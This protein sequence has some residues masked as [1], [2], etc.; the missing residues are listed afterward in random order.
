M[1]VATMPAKTPRLYVLPASHPCA[2]VEVA[3]RLKSIEFKRVD[4]LPLQQLVV[5][6]LRYGGATVPGMRIGTERVAGSRAIMRRLE[7]L[8]ADPP[9]LPAPDDAT[10]ASVLEAERWGDEVFQ[11]V[12][13]R[14]I[15]AALVR[16]P[17]MMESYA[18]GARLPLP[19][20]LLRPAMPLTA[21]LAAMKSKARDENARVDLEA[22]PGQLERIEA[23]MADGVL[24]GERPNVADL[25][26]GASL[27]L[28]ASIGDVRGL[29]VERPAGELMRYFPPMAG[30]VPAGVLPAA[31]LA[32]PAASA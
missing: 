27:R 4:L 7:E 24:G 32:V 26:I 25:Q 21:R 28:L 19:I 29:I 8:E 17:Q 5:G 14:L 16:R 23:W 11:G 18:Q 10:Y 20:A 2:A 1:L 6:P 13:R 22:L 15:Y 31:W 12:A 3:L 30:E 9:L